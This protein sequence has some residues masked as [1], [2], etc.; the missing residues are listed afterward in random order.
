MKMERLAAGIA[1]ALAIAVSQPVLAQGLGRTQKP[2]EVG[3]SSARLNRLTDR[4]KL[5][6]AKGEIPAPGYIKIDVERPSKFGGNVSFS[7]YA[8]LEKTLEA[9]VDTGC[10]A[11]LGLTKKTDEKN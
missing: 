11:G 10:T 6:V 4:I 7:S 5:G 1:F 8:E 2:E 9:Y 3:F